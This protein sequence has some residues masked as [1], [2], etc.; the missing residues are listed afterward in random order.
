MLIAT[1]FPIFEMFNHDK[2]GIITLYFDDLN[3]VN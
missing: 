1:D 3:L 2:Q